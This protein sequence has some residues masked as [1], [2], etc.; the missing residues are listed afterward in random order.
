MEK[1][2]EQ[3]QENNFVENN[4]LQTKSYPF[5]TKVVYSKWRQSPDRAIE[6]TP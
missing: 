3:A 6:A 2:P 5:R 1:S 4:S